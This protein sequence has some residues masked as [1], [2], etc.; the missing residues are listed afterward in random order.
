[1]SRKNQNKTKQK[2]KQRRNKKKKK[3]I[4][5]VSLFT[6]KLKPERNKANTR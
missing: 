4:L 2:K 1:M 5:S 6:C 3:K